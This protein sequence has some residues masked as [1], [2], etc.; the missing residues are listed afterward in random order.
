M[1]TMVALSL[2]LL[3]YS[4]TWLVLAWVFG[5]RRKVGL[6]WSA[7]FA[8]LAVGCWA[9]SLPQ[10]H[11]STRLIVA[12]N[13]GLIGGFYCLMRGLAYMGRYPTTTLDTAAPVGLLATILLLRL[14][15]PDLVA[16][17]LLLFSLCVGWCVVRAAW[18]IRRLLADVGYP[19]LFMPLGLAP[20]ATLL[21]LL[22]VRPLA[23]MVDQG[24]TAGYLLATDSGYKDLVVLAGFVCLMLFNLAMAVVVLGGLVN[25]LRALSQTDTLT[26]L[27]NR[28]AALVAAGQEH[29]RY[30]R[31]GRAYS[32]LVIDVDFFKRVNDTYGHAAGD[33]VLIG[34]AQTMRTCARETDMVAR[35]GGEEFLAFLP[36]T[37]EDQAFYLGERM[38][39]AVSA[40]HFTSLS[41]PLVVTISAGIATVAPDDAT[42]DEVIARADRAL[43]QAKHQGR[44]QV[45]RPSAASDS[46]WSESLSNQPSPQASS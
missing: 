30:R 9:A 16:V 21:L 37:D 38:R 43:Y 35:F 17:R 7:A 42:L 10:W 12:I 15:V 11:E 39:L 6:W 32:V 33:Q 40:R 22:A 18:L 14:T 41:P 34:V 13:I 2:Q 24:G 1:S 23:V 36:D 28:R 5:V 3:L 8:S 27:P 20:V 29:E 46:L 19:R 45:V 4:V 31:S 26:Q 25:R 44:N